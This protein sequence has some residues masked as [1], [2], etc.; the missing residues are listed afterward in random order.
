[1]HFAI[2]VAQ[3]CLDVR[4]VV[5]LPVPTIRSRT[6]EICLGTCGSRPQASGTTRVKFRHTS[7]SRR[8]FRGQDG[9]LV[10]ISYLLGR[11]LTPLFS[12]VNIHAIPMSSCMMAI[13]KRAHTRM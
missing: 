4:L 7:R 8:A 5:L 2:W 1:M 10:Q 12:S 3:L 9:R 13:C 11:D 6:Q